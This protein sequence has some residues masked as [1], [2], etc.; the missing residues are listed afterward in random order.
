MFE[1]AVA[2][3]AHGHA[4]CVTMID[5][6]LVADA[7]AG[8]DDSADACLARDLNTVGEREEGIT[9]SVSTAALPITWCIGS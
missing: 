3:D 1:V 9:F 6:V 5:T 2:G 7:A 4:V 8:M